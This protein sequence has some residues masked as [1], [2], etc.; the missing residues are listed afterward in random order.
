[1]KPAGSAKGFSLIE[2]LLV[3]A[4]LGIIA[5]IAIPSYMGQ[6][7][8][9][10]IIGDAEANTQVLR[11]QLEAYRADNGIYGASG[12]TY[13]WSGSGG[14]VSGGSAAT[15]LNFTPKNASKMKYTAAISSAG[16]KYNI[17]VVDPTTANMVVY[18]VNQ[19]GSAWVAKY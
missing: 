4:I 7:T 12:A 10:R 17:T 8:R 2:L 13:V 9:A 19:A 14:L 16:L 5:G 1:M 15:A 18:K 6:R 11:M 3:L